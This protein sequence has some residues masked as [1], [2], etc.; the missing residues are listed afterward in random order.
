MMLG[1]PHATMHAPTHAGKISCYGVWLNTMSPLN[2]ITGYEKNYLY[3][4]VT[5]QSLLTDMC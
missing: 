5:A 2:S 1:N 3:D 4:I